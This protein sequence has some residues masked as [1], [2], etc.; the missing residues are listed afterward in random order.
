[1]M[2][3]MLCSK[4]INVLQVQVGELFGAVL[5]GRPGRGGGF[6]VSTYNKLGDETGNKK[7]DAGVKIE[8]REKLL[9][10]MR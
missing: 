4:D 5:V 1:M 7:G 10:S 8:K 2:A 3:L 6:A 9:W